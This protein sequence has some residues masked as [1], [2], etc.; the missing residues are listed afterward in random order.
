MIVFRCSCFGF[1]A[2]SRVLL[3]RVFWVCFPVCFASPVALCLFHFLFYYVLLIIINLSRGALSPG[4]RSG[5]SARQ[6]SRPSRRW[7][8]RR[9]RPRK[10]WWSISSSDESGCMDSQ[11]CW[12]ETST[13][14]HR[15]LGG[16]VGASS[17]S[18][19]RSLAGW[20]PRRYVCATP[21][22]GDEIL[23]S[24][25]WQ[26]VVQVLVTYAITSLSIDYYHSHYHYQS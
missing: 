24:L 12:P 4:R 22:G 21:F 6:R 16:S 3:P 14:C 15:S 25:Q 11:F 5:R 1:L 9:L 2:V 19:R 10:G 18:C 13:P 17:H 8:R 26:V 7:P 23:L 20:R